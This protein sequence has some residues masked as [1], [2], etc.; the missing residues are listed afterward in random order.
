MLDEVGADEVPVAPV[1]P[2]GCV[3]GAGCTGAVLEAPFGV[4]VLEEAPVGP[5]A[6]G[7][8]VGLVLVVVGEGPSGVVDSLPHAPTRL[9]TTVRALTLRSTAK[10]CM[11]PLSWGAKRGSNR[12]E[13]LAE[14]NGDLSGRITPAQCAGDLCS[15]LECAAAGE[16]PSN[17]DEPRKANAWS[18]VGTPACAAEFTPRGGSR[19]FRPTRTDRMPGSNR[20]EQWAGG[21]GWEG[22][23]NRRPR[24]GPIHKRQY[25]VPTTL[26]HD[27]HSIA[28]KTDYK[29][30]L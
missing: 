29:M 20:R 12:L 5:V 13:W 26:S 27:A 15:A 6:P 19:T 23:A 9:V 1:L 25:R 3:E 2:V 30:A 4:V 21:M 22:A 11:R 14:K 8:V 24:A 28:P 7:A 18:N 16:P 17:C 10:R